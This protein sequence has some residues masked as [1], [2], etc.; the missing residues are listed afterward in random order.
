MAEEGRRLGLLWAW[1]CHCE[2]LSESDLAEVRAALLTPQVY[3]IEECNGRAWTDDGSRRQRRRLQEDRSRL[4]GGRSSSRDDRRGRRLR[5]VAARSVGSGR[6]L[7]SSSTSS[8]GSSTAN[9][10][11]EGSDDDEELEQMGPVNFLGPLLLLVLCV[12]LAFLRSQ[13]ART[14]PPHP[15]TP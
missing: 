3:H 14:P 15:C 6:R 4:S 11:A 2:G 7:A 9:A 8:S 5:S 10:A 12:V 1:F 13:C